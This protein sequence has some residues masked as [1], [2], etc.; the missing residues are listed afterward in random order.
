MKKEKKDFGLTDHD[1]L[2]EF[3]GVFAAFVLLVGSFVKVI[4]L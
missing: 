4:F 3:V 2:I 1:R